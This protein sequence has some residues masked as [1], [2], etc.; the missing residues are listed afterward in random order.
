[1]TFS[2]FSWNILKSVEFRRV[3]YRIINES[4]IWVWWAQ[5]SSVSGKFMCECTHA[6]AYTHTCMHTYAHEK[7]KIIKIVMVS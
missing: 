3:V 2:S 5:L 4:L 7:R 1:M 6:L